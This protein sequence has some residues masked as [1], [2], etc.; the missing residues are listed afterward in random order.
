[1]PHA[2]ALGGSA[3]PAGGLALPMMRKFTP[4]RPDWTHQITALVHAVCIALRPALAKVS[5]QRSDELAIQLLA[6]TRAD[7][8][9]GRV[10]YTGGWRKRFRRWG[11]ETAGGPSFAKRPDFLREMP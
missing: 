5:Q 1:M 7:R 2:F 6:V 8:G 4:F 9:A 3:N 11:V 10:S